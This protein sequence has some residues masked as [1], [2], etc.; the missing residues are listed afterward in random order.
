VG[1][2]FFLTFSRRLPATISLDGFLVACF[3]QA[4][5]AARTASGVRLKPRHQKKEHWETED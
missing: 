5:G 1:G 3:P 4:I 2:R